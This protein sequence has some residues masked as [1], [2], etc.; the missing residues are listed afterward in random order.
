M[1]FNI[2]SSRFF[3]SSKFRSSVRL[4]EYD[5]RTERDC[6]KNECTDP[7]VDIP[8]EQLIPHEEYAPTSKAQENDIALIRL[9]QS[10]K[11]TSK[12][13]EA[14]TV[15]RTVNISFIVEY[16]KPIC[17]PGSARLK[18][19]IYD[20][21]SLEVAGWGKTENGNYLMFVLTLFID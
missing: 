6:Y 16:I 4:G 8:I 5:L 2:Q 17:L 12:L 18:T 14:T 7:A 11:Y 10:V 21:I 1:E 3:T 19:L 20:G 13:Y 9:S 15:N